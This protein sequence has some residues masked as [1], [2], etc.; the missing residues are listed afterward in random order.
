MKRQ[1]K[2]DG[3]IDLHGYTQDQAFNS[4]SRFLRNA[5]ADGKRQVLVVTGKGRPDSP[6][7]IKIML[8]RWLDY[9]DLKKYVSGY[10]LA[11][12]NLGGSGA[13][14]VKLKKGF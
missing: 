1:I 14:L 11:P 2:I 10:S 3:K 12:I 6:S 7:I 4:L 9:T 13:M 8:P 5:L